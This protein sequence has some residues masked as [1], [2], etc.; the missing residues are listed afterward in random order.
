[1]TLMLA[2]IVGCNT[3]SDSQPSAGF[4]K[5]SGDASPGTHGDDAGVLHTGSKALPKLRFSLADDAY[6]P[7][8]RDYPGVGGGR[9]LV[10]NNLD[11][12]LSILDLSKVDSDAL[13]VLATT[14]VGRNPID[15]EG[16]AHTVADPDG[17]YYYVAV[18]TFLLRSPQAVGGHGRSEADG[19]VLKMRASDN[20]Q[21]DSVRVDRAP[22]DLKITPDGKKLLVSHADG[23]RV[24][25][26]LER[27]LDPAAQDSFL[28][29]ID[30]ATMKREALVRLCPVSR[31]IA[32]SS[33]SATAYVT[34][35]DD[36]V[37]VVD[38]RSADYTTIRIPVV[39]Q[40]G[41]PATPVCGPYAL[42]I[43]PSDRGVWI[44]CFQSGQ[45]LYLDAESGAIDPARSV[46]LSGP[47]SFGA[48]SP[49]A[50]TLA[51]PYRRS[52][53][54]L[55]SQRDG[56]MPTTD[57]LAVIDSASA[58]VRRQIALPPSLC[59]NP[60]A[61]QYTP[62]GARML[63]V[64]EGN[65]TGQGT[66]LVID[67]ANGEL[68]RVVALGHFANSL[69]LLSADP[70]RRVAPAP[71]QM[72][73]AGPS[74]L[75]PPEANAIAAAD[76]G[77]ALFSDPGFADSGFNA[78]SCATCHAT[79]VP[80]ANAAARTSIAASMRGVASR[81]TWWGGA[82]PRL[83]DAVNACFTF[84]M[85]GEPLLP[86]DARGRA[87]YEY[88]LKLSPN[89][90]SDAL[91]FTFVQGVDAL[92]RGEP[93]RGKAAYEASCKVCH[94]EPYS[95]K[96]RISELVSIIPQAIVPWA[97]GAFPGF[98]KN[99]FDPALG[100]I[101]KVRHGQFLG[102]G[103]NM[104]FFTA[105]ALSDADL[106]AVIGYLNLCSMPERRPSWNCDQ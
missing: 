91:P 49:D 70:T 6:W 10:S 79:D 105:E 18:S 30:L 32:V 36:R 92:Q 85:R 66:L 87:L 33:D 58:V 34:C 28:A 1:M 90:Q 16:P 65:R 72:A 22:Y 46:Q 37:A 38:L 75:D 52:S 82:A 27:G 12:T 23:L 98:E 83:L 14:P 19:Y 93:N 3:R 89:D 8:R 48:F 84:F 86:D 69:T 24:L 15:P 61:V 11:D 76:Y 104:P 25:E 31:G 73:N 78:F 44:S 99:D 80:K 68:E 26:S 94:G 5:D 106:A 95:G 88:L 63:L 40:P 45:V 17:A 13:T 62:D 9:V 43:D 41:P 100:I 51:V 59:A 74:K 81:R 7:D 71:A 60:H 21:I 57:G 55:V 56:A 29:I 4:D 39:D 103:G 35:I 64:C 20:V 2:S 101:D 42:S 53:E 102:L 97:T 50:A 47:A 67:A 77:E 96:G 54:S